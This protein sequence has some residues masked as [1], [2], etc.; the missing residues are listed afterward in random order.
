MNTEETFYKVLKEI[1]KNICPDNLEIL[2]LEIGLKTDVDHDLKI[3]ELV[4]Q[5]L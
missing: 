5:Y 1:N 2:C 3:F 4:L